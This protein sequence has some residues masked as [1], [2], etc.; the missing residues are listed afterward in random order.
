M[1]RRQ[2]PAT[3]QVWVKKVSSPSK[4]QARSRKLSPVKNTK[5]LPRPHVY[6]FNV[7]NIDNKRIE[8]NIAETPSR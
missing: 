3:I 6:K 5:K 2:V 4:V 1:L 7:L 8:V